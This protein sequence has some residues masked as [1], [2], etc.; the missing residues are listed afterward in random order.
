MV[1]C[2]PAGAESPPRDTPKCHQKI[3]SETSGNNLLS[4]TVVGDALAFDVAGLLEPL[5]KF[6]AGPSVVVRRCRIKQLIRT[7]FNGLPLFAW[8]RQVRN[9]Q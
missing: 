1:L 6:C 7:G 9:T 3:G 8:V 4:P 2:R 5:T